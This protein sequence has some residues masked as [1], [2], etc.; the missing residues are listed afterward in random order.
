LRPLVAPGASDP[1]R[2][3]RVHSKAH[4]PD[5]KSILR[6]ELALADVTPP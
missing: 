6:I 4:R 3:F 2:D 5:V 1:K